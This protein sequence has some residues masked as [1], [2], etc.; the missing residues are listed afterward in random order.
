MKGKSRWIAVACLMAV[1]LT[2]WLIA[3]ERPVEAGGDPARKADDADIRKMSEGLARA[4][5]K[6]DAK[7]VGAF[8]T[9][10]GEYVDEDSPPISG[11]A[12]LEKAYGQ[13]FAKRE[14]VKVVSK[15]D[16]IR[17]VGRDTA[18][19]DGIFSVHV[20]DRPTQTSKYST[21]YVRQDGRWLVG[22][23]KEW[24]DAETSR[25]HLHDLAW[26]I[27]TWEGDGPE[28]SARTTFEWAEGKKFMLCKFTLTQNKDKSTV[29]TGTQVI[30]VDPA[31]DFIR[32]WTFTSD[33]GI[34]EASWTYDGDRWVIDS[35][36]TL[37]DGTM[38]TAINHMNRAGDDLFTW[39]SVQ[40]TI[41]GERQPDIAAVKVRRIK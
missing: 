41:D 25:P 10:E 2:A 6:G 38:T 23:L 4:F 7:A 36:A 31:Y 35:R 8:F 17:F 9:E 1:G 15:I 24:G 37:A 22:L 29:S 18:I 26:L 34:G 27:G 12:A 21:L 20:K 28:Q 3:Q 40:R 30:G 11:R 13:F 19:E 33:G 16:K 32:S 39:R 5:E 14:A